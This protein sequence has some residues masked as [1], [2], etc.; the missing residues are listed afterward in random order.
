MELEQNQLAVLSRR[1][2]EIFGALLSGITNK[3]IAEKYFISINTVKT[4][5]KQIYHKLNLRNR[6]DL[7][8]KYK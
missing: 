4:H 1:E 7:M 5:T 6:I 8:S 2:Q 3:E